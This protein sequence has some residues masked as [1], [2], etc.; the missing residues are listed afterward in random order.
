V[1]AVNKIDLL[2]ESGIRERLELI[3]DE[4]LHGVPISAMMNTNLEELLRVIDSNLPSLTRYLVTLPYNDES[5]SLVSRLHD[6]S[7]VRHQDF[8][9]GMVRVEVI[10]STEMAQRLENELPIGSLTKL[11]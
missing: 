3:S 6:M 1:V 5:M 10:L 2:E 4:S 11:E 8:S 7:S 9:H